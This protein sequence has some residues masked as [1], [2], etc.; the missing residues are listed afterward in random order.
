MCEQCA[1]PAADVEI[2]RARDA[3]RLGEIQTF[4]CDLCFAEVRLDCRAAHRWW[5]TGLAELVAQLE[6]T[7][8][9]RA[10]LPASDVGR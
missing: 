1:A 10:D 4:T 8:G 7:T 2:P 5:H 9:V 3:R 6:R